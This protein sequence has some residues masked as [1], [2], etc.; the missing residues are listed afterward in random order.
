VSTTEPASPKS[1][2][3]IRTLFEAKARSEL[4]SADAAAPGSDRVPSVGALLAGLALVKGLPGPAESTGGAA[5]S[6]ADGTAAD[7]A[8]AALGYDPTCAFRML[9]RPEPGIEA[10]RRAERLRLAIEAVDPEVVVALD[11]EAAEDL[12][13]AFGTAPLRFGKPTVVTGRIMLAVD[14]LE[15]SLADLPRKRKVW[16]QLQ[17][18][19]G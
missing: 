11:A 3:E 14:G 18:L 8:L 16:R 13:E 7:L 5:L 1:A 12:A 19:K 6:G 17:A 4:D 10:P 9:S 15:A 2:D